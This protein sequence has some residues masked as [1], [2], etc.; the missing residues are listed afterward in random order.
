MT[1]TL[2]LQ[3]N[4][5][6]EMEGPLGELVT[7]GEDMTTAVSVEFGTMELVGDAVLVM[8]ARA[9]VDVFTPIT[10]GVAV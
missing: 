8:V 1:S 6:M 9:G 3:P 5:L 10:T 2:V 4:T 7:E